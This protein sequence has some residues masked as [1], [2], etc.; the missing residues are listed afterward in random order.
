[1][2]SRCAAT[3]NVGMAD[4]VNIQL[5]SSWVT[6]GVRVTTF[7]VFLGG[8]IAVGVLYLVNELVK[9]TPPAPAVKPAADDPQPITRLATP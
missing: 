5:K 4:L 1:M 6:F 9:S 7:H 3:Q 2:S 8:A